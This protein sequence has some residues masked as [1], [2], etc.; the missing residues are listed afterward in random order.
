MNEQLSFWSGATKVSGRALP[1]YLNQMVRLRVEGK[2][3]VTQ[4]F[5]LKVEP[6]TGGFRI[7]IEVHPYPFGDPPMI[8]DLILRKGMRVRISLQ[9]DLDQP[10]I[11]V[12][13]HAEE[14]RT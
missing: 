8:N 5:L 4:G 1:G 10:T 2:N 6:V 14:I 3:Q 11:F 13:S 7:E 9:K 12:V